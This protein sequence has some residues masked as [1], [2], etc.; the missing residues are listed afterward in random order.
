MI[1]DET[2]EKADE[3]RDGQREEAECDTLESARTAYAIWR[4]NY[5]GTQPPP[6][7]DYLGDDMQQVAVGMYRMGASWGKKIG[8]GDL[9]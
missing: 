7:W 2:P 8:F 5:R 1:V 4:G 9:D 6:H 3:I